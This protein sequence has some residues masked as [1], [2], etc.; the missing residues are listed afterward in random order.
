MGVTL[1]PGGVGTPPTDAAEEQQGECT[2][3]PSVRTPITAQRHHAQLR[4]PDEI[5]KRGSLSPLFNAT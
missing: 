1:T 4:H 3:L 2:H 5:A